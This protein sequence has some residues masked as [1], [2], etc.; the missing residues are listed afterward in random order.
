MRNSEIATSLFH[1]G[2]TATRLQDAAKQVEDTARQMRED[3]KTGYAWKRPVDTN[4]FM[5]MLQL[6][7]ELEMREALALAA[8]ATDEDVAETYAHQEA[9]DLMDWLS[10]QYP[11][12]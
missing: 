6:Q 4:S 9:G 1:L 7:K 5:Q 8:G 10:E 11:G 12:A 3:A 2:T